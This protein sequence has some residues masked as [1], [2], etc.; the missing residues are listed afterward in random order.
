ME[1]EVFSK[2]TVNEFLLPDKIF[3]NVTEP[4]CK[5]YRKFIKI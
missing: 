5:R 2:W 4:L 1:G 3:L